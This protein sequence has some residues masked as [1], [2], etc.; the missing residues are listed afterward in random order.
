MLEY[1]EASEIIEVAGLPVALRA[2]HVK[3]RL[4]DAVQRIA[5]AFYKGG[6]HVP[7]GPEQP[8]LASGAVM[9]TAVDIFKRLTYTAILQ[10]Q[11]DKTTVLYLGEANH[12][13]RREPVAAGDFA[14]LPPGAQQVLRVGG[15]SSRTMAFHVALSGSEV[16]AWYARALSQ[17][18]WRRVEEE[19]GLYTRSGEELRVVHEPGEGGL[20]AV[21][22]VYR[23]AQA[24][25]AKPASP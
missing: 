16:D 22:L 9:L 14:P 8:Q 17:H 3:E 5:D 18:G 20:R 2:V 23:A 10:P 19:A 25:V 12:M 7:P 4:P 6:L 21:V 13:L 1:V 24:A 11:P 15:E